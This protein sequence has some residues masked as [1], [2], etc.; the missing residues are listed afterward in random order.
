MLYISKDILAQLLYTLVV[1]GRVAFACIQ[2]LHV[3]ESGRVMVASEI[4][5]LS[6][7]LGALALAQPS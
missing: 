6:V 5:C 7:G 2:V 1:G 3:Y 4:W